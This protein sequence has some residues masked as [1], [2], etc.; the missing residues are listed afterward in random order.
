[1]T[2]RRNARRWRM[3]VAST[4]TAMVAVL[5]T[6]APAYA[7][8]SSTVWPT[9]HDYNWDY[10]REWFA[11]EATTM[12]AGDCEEKNGYVTLSPPD[13]DGNV[14]MGWGT[15]ILLTHHTNHADVWHQKFEFM[16]AWGTTVLTVGGFDGPQMTKINWEYSEYHW[17]YARMDPQL[18]PL[19]S[20]VRW[21]GDC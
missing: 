10:G 13:A 4:A 5:A 3:F 8:K 15:G 16:T 11:V 2:D 21:T 17:Q 9:Q 6:Q 19:I 14:Y 18:W 20:Q 1:M 7:A 12:S